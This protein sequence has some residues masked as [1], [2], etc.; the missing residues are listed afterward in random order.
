MARYTDKTPLTRKAIADYS[1]SLRRIAAMLD[2]NVDLMDKSKIEVVEATHFDSS[3]V[4]MEK[5]KKF[6]GAITEAIA[7]YR[8]EQPQPQTPKKKSP[9]PKDL[10]KQ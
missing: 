3:E 7:D 4:A 1:A 10:K 9:A 8:P 6:C 5:L 2:G